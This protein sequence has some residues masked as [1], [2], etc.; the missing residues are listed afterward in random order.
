MAI[1]TCRNTAVLRVYLWAIKTVRDALRNSA[2]R[3]ERT[4][5]GKA[6]AAANAAITTT[7]RISIRVNPPRRRRSAGR[8]RHGWREAGMEVG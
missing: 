3:I 1:G 6:M 5:P 7:M 8:T 4:N 2:P